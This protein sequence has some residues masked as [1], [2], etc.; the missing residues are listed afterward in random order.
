MSASEAYPAGRMIFQ[1]CFLLAL[2]SLYSFSTWSEKFNEKGGP[3]PH[4][5]QADLSLVYSCGTFGAFA[6]PVG[7]YIY[8][9]YGQ[10]AT[11]AAGLA[12][13]LTGLSGMV[14][15]LKY[16]SADWSVPTMG[17]FYYLEEQ[18]SST[19][20]MAIACD[21]L[22]HF[23]ASKTSFSM[24]LVSLG[25]SLSSMA[26][27]WLVARV[28]MTL[29][30]LLTGL[31][32]TVMAFALLRIGLV[33]NIHSG[34]VDGK[35]GEDGGVDFAALLVAPRAHKLVCLSAALAPCVAFLSIL[36]AT[37]D[38]GASNGEWV[39]QMGFICNALG[40]ILI[41][42]LFDIAKAHMS[43]GQ[44]MVCL[45]AGL[46]GSFGLLWYTLSGTMYHPLSFHAPLVAASCGL[47][48]LFFGGTS[49]I[50]SVYIKDSFSPH[51]QGM[52][53]G[54]Q[55]LCVAI[56]NFAFNLLFAPVSMTAPSLAH[57]F[58][59]SAFLCALTALAF[60][61]PDGVADRAE[62]VS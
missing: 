24:G 9:K 32:C 13:V 50:V 18:G 25:F 19:L 30:H 23:P 59:M 52:V 36:K 16:V 29:Y 37:G 39:V 15:T 53:L 21:T 38:I 5:T 40:R 20:Y 12:L 46:S 10:T 35:S 47:V 26:S 43:S 6:T 60:C 41:G 51:V 45:I 55:Q 62:K 17:A 56:S 31:G 57:T 34:V 54:L 3:F 11:Y 27:A 4:W 2:G 61:I 33:G 1:I 42:A 7:G 58:R 44:A 48:L 14:V 49:P 28:E 22:L 8:S